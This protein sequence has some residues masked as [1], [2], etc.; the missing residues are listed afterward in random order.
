LRWTVAVTVFLWSFGALAYY[1]GTGPGPGLTGNDT[2]GIIQWTPS[3]QPIYRNLAADWCAQWNRR[4]QITSV[5]RRYGEYVG[6]RC[7]YDRRYDPRR[8]SYGQWWRIW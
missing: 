8:A 4:A 7:L 3:V 1:D 2:G 6:F 5:N